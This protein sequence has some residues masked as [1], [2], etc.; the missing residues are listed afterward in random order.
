MMIACVTF[1]WSAQLDA[2][3]GRTTGASSTQSALPF[4]LGPFA[5]L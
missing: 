3:P 5:V 4:T 2:R 1:D